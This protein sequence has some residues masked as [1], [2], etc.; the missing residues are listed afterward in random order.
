MLRLSGAFA[1]A[2]GAG[3]FIFGAPL[4]ARLYGSA[5]VGQYVRVLALAAPFMYLESMVDGVLKGLGEQLA[6]FRYSLLDSA[7]RI[8]AIVLLLPKY[9]MP[10]FLGI[11]VASNALTCTL[12]TL[13]MR[14]MLR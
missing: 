10:A 3:F 1:L 8:P 14:K 6:T 4:A 11:M 5:A 2:A 13:R 7:L 9:G 12:N